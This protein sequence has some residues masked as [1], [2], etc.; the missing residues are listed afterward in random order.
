MRCA[1]LLLLVVIIAGTLVS[2]ALPVFSPDAP[3]QPLLAALDICH[4]PDG[5]LSGQD[6]NVFLHLNIG[7][8]RPLVLVSF[9]KHVPCS[10]F[11]PLIPRRNDLPP[12]A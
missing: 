3:A 1:A 11:F 12:K 9:S 7:V 5:A 8:P 10:L 4:A 2:H 6:Q